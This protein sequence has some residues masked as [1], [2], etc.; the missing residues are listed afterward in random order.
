M[1]YPVITMGL[2]LIIL[3]MF[4]KARGLG[5]VLLRP[6]EDSGR[7]TLRKFQGE[8]IRKF[9]FATLLERQ[10]ILVSIKASN[11]LPGLSRSPR[12]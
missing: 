10:T 1:T 6:F 4:S 11:P 3:W 9:N 5:L 8:A 7:P 2:N 12:S